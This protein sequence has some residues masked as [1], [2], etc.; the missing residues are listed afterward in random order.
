MNA[1]VGDWLIVRNAQGNRHPRQ[2]E[3]LRVSL[4]GKPPYTVR[5]LEDDHEAIV[6]PGPDFEVVTAEQRTK[7]DSSELARISRVQAEIAAHRH[8]NG[9][10][11]S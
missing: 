4:D 9:E 7:M 5:W 6:F 8:P 1:R 3:I 10:Q 11:P 2:A